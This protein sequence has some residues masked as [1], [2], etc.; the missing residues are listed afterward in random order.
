MR[1]GQE[2]T[3]RDAFRAIAVAAVAILPTG[4]NAVDAAGTPGRGLSLRPG[5]AASERD[6]RLALPALWDTAWILP[7]ADRPTIRRYLDARVS[8]GFD[9][10]LLGAT[11]WAMS[12]DPLGNGQKP[13]SAERPSADGRPVG[14][15]AH[16]NERGFTYL[17]EVIQE[18]GRRGLTAG[19]LP[20]S[21]GDTRRYLRALTDVHPGERRAY[22]YGLYLGRRYRRD[23][24][25]IW[26]LGGD[27]DPASDARVI[28]LTRFLAGGIRDGGALQPMTF[29]PGWGSSSR[30]FE[31]DPWLDFNMIQ[32]GAGTIRRM[33][34]SDRRLSKPTGL[35]EG[36]YEGHAP[37]EVVR[38]S[39]YVTYL[40]GGAYVTYGNA[41]TCC[42]GPYIGLD[43][44]GVAYARIARDLMVRRG[45]LDYA[46]DHSLIVRAQGDP[47]AAVKRNVAAMVYLTGGTASATID[48][49]KLNAT[50]RVRIRRFNPADGAMVSLGDVGASG[51]RR[52][53]T[54]GLPDAVLLLDAR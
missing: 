53:D 1:M 49:S 17:D 52:F 16:P 47:I 38:A 39:A 37:A 18:A 43:T 5:R 46:P 7:L 11:D 21:N 34:Q 10:V 9:A 23:A 50:G 41:R 22:R 33:V 6:S 40:S 27:V 44:P 2:T 25:I 19:F 45:W 28:T 35:G 20:M 15:V 26:V 29:H 4:V 54:G 32:G 3:R 13:F 12:N 36:P 51:T 14:D 24:N 48:L 30:W 42:G 8:Q 31:R